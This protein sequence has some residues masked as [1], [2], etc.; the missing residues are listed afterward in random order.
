MTTDEPA[1]AAKRDR[2]Q[3]LLQQQIPHLLVNGDLDNRLAGN[4]HICVPGIP[5]SAVIA[6]VRDRLAISTGSACS[7]GVETP[8]HVL[9]AIEL[10]EDAIEGALG[11]SEFV[12]INV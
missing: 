1:I 6:R 3:T 9:R 12:V 11:S 10:P 4:L 8:S 2:L 7:S 5:N